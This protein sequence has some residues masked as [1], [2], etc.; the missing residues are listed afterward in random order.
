M[1]ERER[2]GE[3]ERGKMHAFELRKGCWKKPKIE[4]IVLKSKAE[5]NRQNMEERMT[6][7]KIE[8]G[9][10]KDSIQC[11]KCVKKE[12]TKEKEKKR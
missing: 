8:D 1:R 5:L 9:H 3:R 7:T 12:G 10:K 4:K 6:F 11:E 2:E